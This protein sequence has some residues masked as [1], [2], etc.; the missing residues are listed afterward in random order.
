MT[1]EKGIRW[2][3]DRQ[4]WLV[5]GR[6]KIKGQPGPGRYFSRSFL[7]TSTAK[8]RREWREDQRVKIRIGL[9]DEAKARAIAP[10]F[11]ADALEYLQTV[12]ALPTWSERKQHIEEWIEA[13]GD[14]ARSSITSADIRRQR[15]EW[16]TI[17]PRRERKR[18]S[19]GKMAWVQVNK[20]LAPSSV[21]HR[22]RALQNLWTVLDGRHAKNPV[23]EV[24]EADEPE[25][26]PRGIPVAL[27][28]QILAA[29]SNRGFATKGAKR[30]GWSKAKARLE[31][32]AWLGL[33]PAQLALL[34]P[35][36]VDWDGGTAYVRRRKK[37]KGVAGAKRP[38]TA[39]GL[40]A[41]KALDTVGAWG[42]FTMTPVRRAWD[43]ACRKVEE[44]AAAAGV[45]LSLEAVTPY[46]LRHSFG[47]STLAA[48]KS[49]PAT[50]ALLGHADARTTLR[51][52]R[53]AVPAWLQAAAEQ[54]D[55]HL[56]KQAKKGKATGRGGA[57]KRV[58]KLR[59]KSRKSKS[60][61][62]R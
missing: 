5:Y 15:D 43:R 12:R 8:E 57:K 38:L 61:R 36:D 19:N 58:R 41:L 17:G 14:R 45:T 1:R 55:A 30:H 52:A 32:M 39:K 20:P 47:T 60:G 59:G 21:N 50:Q 62:K 16:L 26:E 31:V 53:A 54:L 48:T 56:A 24:P 18:Q 28:V 22:L 29:V 2:L 23:R 10:G 7:P 35:E 11:R 33:P 49:L 25:G 3:P 27:I 4:R 51:Y 9:E 42:A 44:D 37:G 6:V 13:F 34:R 46:A 40:E